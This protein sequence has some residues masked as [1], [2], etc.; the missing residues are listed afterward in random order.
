M[1]TIR[2]LFSWIVRFALLYVLF[3]VCFIIGSMAVAGVMPHCSISRSRKRV[4]SEKSRFPV[5][6][7]ASGYITQFALF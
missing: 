5:Q 3:I 4:F 2:S 1:N 7:N 6:V